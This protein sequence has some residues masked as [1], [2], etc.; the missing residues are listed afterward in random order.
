MG[1]LVFKKESLPDINRYDFDLPVVRDP[2]QPGARFP[3]R[4]QRPGGL[5]IRQNQVMVRRVRISGHNVRVQS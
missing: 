5:R 2:E 1:H 3:V 4:A